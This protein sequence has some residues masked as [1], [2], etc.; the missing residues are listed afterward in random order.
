MYNTVKYRIPVVSSKIVR[1]RM[2]LHVSFKVN[3]M[4]SH[5]TVNVPRPPSNINGCKR[6][7][8][9]KMTRRSKQNISHITRVETF[10]RQ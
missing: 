10:S 3:W 2:P 5:S 9:Q 4:V 7:M 1:C 8:L 6:K